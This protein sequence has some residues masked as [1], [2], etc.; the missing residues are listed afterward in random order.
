[1]ADQ[2]ED[3][4]YDVKPDESREPN[5][6]DTMSPDRVE[7]FI[8]GELTLGQLYGITI[9]EAY[10]IAEMGYT[11]MEQGRLKDA[12]TVFQG[13]VIS[14]PYDGYFHAV[15]GAIYQKLGIVDGA[16]EEYTL[17]LGL[18]PGNVEAYVNRGELMIAKGNFAQAAADFKKAI[19][20]DPDGE[21]PVANRARA[22]ASIVAA[23]LSSAISQK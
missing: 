20:L 23:A 13:L 1:M 8:M 3:K 14:N 18:D 21:N 5:L 15:L 12:Q 10:S 4:V 9:E 7:K 6:M 22:L 16:I 19:D 11:M 2:K 17:A